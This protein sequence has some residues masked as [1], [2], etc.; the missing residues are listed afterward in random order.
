MGA[1]SAA[2]MVC[3]CTDSCRLSKFK[4]L[5]FCD[6]TE[7]NDEYIERPFTSE[8]PI[9]REY[10]PSKIPM[11]SETESRVNYVEHDIPKH[12]RL[13][14]RIEYHVSHP[15]CDWKSES[16][17]KYPDWKVKSPKK[18]DRTYIPNPAPMDCRTTS[19]EAFVRYADIDY[20]SP[21]PAMAKKACKTIE[22]RSRF[23]GETT[24]RRDYTPKDLPERP[25]PPPEY[26]I[27]KENREFV[28]TSHATYVPQ[29]HN[30]VTQTVL[31]PERVRPFALSTL[32]FHSSTTQKESYVPHDIKSK[33]KK[34]VEWQP[35][36]HKAA[37]ETT[38]S[39]S[40][41]PYGACPDDDGCGSGKKGSRFEATTMSAVRAQ[42]C[43]TIPKVKLD[44]H[45]SYRDSYRGHAISPV[46]R[47]P[48]PYRPHKDNRDFLTTASA[49]YTPPQVPQELSS[50]KQSA[51]RKIPKSAQRGSPHACKCRLH[52]A[53]C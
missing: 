25:P 47:K 28:S 31:S 50:P 34:Q 4:S 30:A 9:R 7:Y 40:Y 1:E 18:H 42:D 21:A 48:K 24:N 33:Q 16:H 29:D 41:R 36:P 44:A 3:T 11:S 22:S 39:V 27:P 10:S 52:C 19:G 12:E 53:R 32:Q 51:R 13:A 46:A 17:D 26:K 15:K 37:K 2:D 43:V 45:T 38:M 8:K 5:S 20:H 14:E 49:T 35:S 6:R 23:Y